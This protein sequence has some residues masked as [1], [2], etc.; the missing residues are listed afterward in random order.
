MRRIMHYQKQLLGIMGI[1]VCGSQALAQPASVSDTAGALID[2]IVEVTPA[3]LPDEVKTPFFWNG[4]LMYKPE[5]IHLLKEALRSYDEKIPLDVLLPSLFPKQVAEEVDLQP[6][7]E[8]DVVLPE[9]VEAPENTD[10]LPDAA[11]TLPEKDSHVYLNSILY[12]SEQDWLV[13]LNNEMLTPQTDHAY[14][15]LVKVDP[16]EVVII[17]KDMPLDIVYPDWQKSFIPFGS[18]N[19]LTNAK[20][21]VINTETQNVSFILRP[22]QAFIAE[23]M[24][25]IEGRYS[26]PIIAP[27]P[28][29]AEAEGEGALVDPNTNAAG[30]ENIT[31]MLPEQMQQQL[32]LLEQY[33]NQLLLLQNSLK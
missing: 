16:D 28:I 6:E 21:I 7:P 13:W 29:E 23:N 9:V 31:Q 11:T 30:M 1:L 26:A 15:K 5:D 12:I 3:Q 8:A 25:V 4:S 14:L 27:L 20:N 18:K 19:F 24:E 17:W 2:K 32:Q 10:I 22:N 33:K